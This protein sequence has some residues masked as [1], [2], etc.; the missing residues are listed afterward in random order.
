MDL[1]SHLYLDQYLLIL[2]LRRFDLP[3]IKLFCSTFLII[4]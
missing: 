3:D 4:D 2:W 1:F